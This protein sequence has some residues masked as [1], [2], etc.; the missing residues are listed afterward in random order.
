MN[1]L[2]VSGLKSLNKEASLLDTVDVNLCARPSCTTWAYGSQKERMGLPPSCRYKFQDL[3]H[4]YNYS[5]D[6][7]I[8]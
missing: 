6:R 2:L 1:S 4:G 3:D 5:L 7:F 8:L